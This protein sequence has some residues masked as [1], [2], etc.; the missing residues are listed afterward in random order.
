MDQQ[1]CVDA[2]KQRINAALGAFTPIGHSTVDKPS[3]AKQENTGM[4]I[5]LNPLTSCGG[6]TTRPMR[7]GILAAAD[8]GG[9]QGSHAGSLSK[10]SGSGGPAENAGTYE[11]ECHKLILEEFEDYDLGTL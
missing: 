5:T 1:C 3:V 9:G 4:T 11:R 10:G 7:V 2:D 8:A 6:E